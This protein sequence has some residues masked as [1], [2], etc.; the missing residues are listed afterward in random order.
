MAEIK[1]DENMKEGMYQRAS[2]FGKGGINGMHHNV[3]GW[4]NTTVGMASSVFD[5]IFKHIR[6]RFFYSK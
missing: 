6:S 3:V 5:N 1:L 4:D 2:G